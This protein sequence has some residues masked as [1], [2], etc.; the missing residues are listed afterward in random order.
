MFVR[1]SRYHGKPERVDNAIHSAER[2]LLSLE[3]IRGFKRFLFFV[4]RN[5]GEAMSISLW[6]SLDSVWASAALVAPLREKVAESLGVLD[7]P[8][9]EV[10]EMVIDSGSQ[11]DRAA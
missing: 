10:Y 7:P 5:T 6:D 1:V 4:D 2:V 9:A 3:G 8:T 11:A